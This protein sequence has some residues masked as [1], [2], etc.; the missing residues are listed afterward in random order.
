VPS[1]TQGTKTL[2]EMGVSYDQPPGNRRPRPWP[3]GG[4]A[5]APGCPPTAAA[6]NARRS[7][8][9][10]FRPRLVMRLEA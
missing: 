8:G 1:I 4:N 7:A 3:D 10:D 2:D 5:I 6:E 9:E